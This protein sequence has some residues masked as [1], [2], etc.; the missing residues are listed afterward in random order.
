MSGLQKDQLLFESVQ[1][2]ALLSRQPVVD[3]DY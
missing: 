1:H 2:S 3:P